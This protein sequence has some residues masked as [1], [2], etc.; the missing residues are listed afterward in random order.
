VV[1][2]KLAAEMNESVES[3]ALVIPR[4]SGRPVAGRPP[5]AMTRSFS[6]AEAELVHLLL[7]EEGSVAHVLDLD[8]AHHLARDRLDV[9]VVDVDALEAVNLLNGIHQV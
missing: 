4:R 8:P 5:S 2:W 1:S 3:E 6:L 9:L 7:E